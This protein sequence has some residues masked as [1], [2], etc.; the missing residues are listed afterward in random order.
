MGL[1]IGAIHMQRVETKTSPEREIMAKG[2]K[3]VVASFHQ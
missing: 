1:D 3:I 2:D